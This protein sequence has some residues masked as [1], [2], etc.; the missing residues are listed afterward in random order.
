MNR[1]CLLAVAAALTVKQ[2]TKN[3]KGRSR[4][5]KE[6]LLKRS[7]LGYSN[8]LEELRLEPGD[9]HNYLR[10]KEETY[11]K[12]LKLVTPLIKKCDTHLRVSISPH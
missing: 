12:L 2:K 1:T 7:T 5:T 8:L 10:M 3:R 11:F 6:W 9:W 4:W